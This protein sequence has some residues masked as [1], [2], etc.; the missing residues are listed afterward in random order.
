VA[1]AMEVLVVIDSDSFRISKVL[2][3]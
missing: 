2:E 1:A 3:A